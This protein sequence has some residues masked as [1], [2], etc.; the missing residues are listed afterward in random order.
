MATTFGGWPILQEQPANGVS[1]PGQQGAFFFVS[2]EVAQ[3]MHYLV[4][5]LDRR[6]E[7]AA[8]TSGWRRPGFDPGGQG[9]R[10]NH[11]GG[12]AM[13]QNGGAHPYEAH[14]LDAGGS[15][16]LNYSTTQVRA[17][18]AIMAELSN[19]AGRTVIR[20]GLDFRP[21]LRDPM[22]F[23]V[24][25]ADGV[26]SAFVSNR[27]V[28]EA[29]LRVL[30]TVSAIQAAVRATVD[31]LWGPK[32]Q[33][34]V[35][36]VRQRARNSPLDSS[37]KIVQQVVRAPREDGVWDDASQAALLETVKA[38]QRAFKVDDDGS[39]GPVTDAAYAL[40]R[41]KFLDYKPLHTG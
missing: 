41:T 19:D 8:L 25:R 4:H 7:R 30:R 20:W 1:G 2:P 6:V 24:G 40:Q 22:H 39:W 9:G 38:L 5:Q 12:I 15:W 18:R 16:R 28:A 14:V 33:R 21:G 17:I 3:A 36:A 35:L 13:D 23:E 37:V 26:G 29:N 27:E 11:H 32:T 10:S 31:R 34:R